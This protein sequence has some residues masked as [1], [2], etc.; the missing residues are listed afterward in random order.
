M[1]LVLAYCLLWNMLKFESVLTD[2]CCFIDCQI[3]YG[4]S[5]YMICQSNLKT[6]S[7]VHLRIHS[8]TYTF[9]VK[10]M[11]VVDFGYIACL[12][13]VHVRSVMLIL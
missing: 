7:P 1:I 11:F 13:V 6:L 8:G 2:V 12:G 4:K 3:D 10:Q 9:L 5:G